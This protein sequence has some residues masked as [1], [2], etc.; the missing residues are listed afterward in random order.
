MMMSIEFQTLDGES[1]FVTASGS[2]EEV[3]AWLKGF[4][5]ERPLLVTRIVLL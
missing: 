3:A 2:R 1:E 4:F 5:T